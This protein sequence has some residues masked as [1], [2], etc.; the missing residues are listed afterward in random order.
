MK[1][2]S[3]AL[4]LVVLTGHTVAL[5]NKGITKRLP[6]LVEMRLPEVMGLLAENPLLTKP[7]AILPIAGLQDKRN[8]DE[9]YGNKHKDGR[10]AFK[11][12][13]IVSLGASV[14][15]YFFVLAEPIED[16]TALESLGVMAAFTI[17]ATF[18][19]KGFKAKNELTKLRDV[20]Q[21]VEADENDNHIVIYDHYD[22]YHVGLLSNTNEGFT[23]V[24]PLGN[25]MSVKHEQLLHFVAIG[26]G[27]LSNR[28]SF[29]KKNDKLCNLS[30][31]TPDCYLGKTLAFK[32]QGENNIGTIEDI[33]F[34]ADGRG[35][36]VVATATGE[37]LTITSGK[38]G[39][40]VVVDAE[41]DA[42]STD[43]FR[44]VVFLPTEK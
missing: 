1:I 44:G 29:I 34:A 22:G 14:Y 21:V 33:S 25:E 31:D 28:F 10:N 40:P 4:M 6:R 3:L 19:V 9:W 41:T 2:F 38:R 36:L 17:G 11:A 16:L 35:S 5:A 24:D 27:L 42:Q 18:M 20:F 43:Q 32:Y 12:G 13:A 39:E 30:A 8:I 15:S 7:L 26:D 23:V 37:E